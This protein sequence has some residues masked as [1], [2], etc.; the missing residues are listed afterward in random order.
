[1]KEMSSGIALLDTIL[2]GGI[3][4]YST[5]IVAGPPGSGKTILVQQLM[6][7]YIR[8]HENAKVLYL[9]TLSEPSLKVVRYMQRFQFFDAE[10]FGKRA[11]YSDIGTFIFEESLLKLPKKIMELVDL[12]QPDLVTID[13][14]QAIGDLSKNRGEF[15]RLCYNLSVLFA[16][17]RC[18]TFLVS[19]SR[20]EQ[21]VNGA[22][23]AIADGIIYLDISLKEQLA[24]RSLQV[25][26]LRG[27]SP[28]MEVFPFKLSDRGIEILSPNLSLKQK[29][30]APRDNNK[31]IATAIPGL[32]KLLR[33]G[34]PMGRSI[35]LSGVSGTGK[36]TFALQFLVKGA[37]LGQKGLLISFEESSDRLHETASSF[38]W[39]FAE[40]EAKGLLDIVFFPP[41]QIRVE[42]QLEDIVELVSQ[43]QP[44]RL[45]IDSFSVFLYKIKDPAIQ[46]EKI[47][48]LTNLIQLCGAVGLLL[49]DIPASAPESLSRFGVEETVVDGTIILTTSKSDPQLSTRG[50]RRMRYLE[51]Y[52]M[53]GINHITGSHPFEIAAD[54]IKILNNDFAAPINNKNQ[55]SA[56]ISQT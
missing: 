44:D 27:K 18:T 47:I 28:L 16:T 35:L 22:E 42:E 20:R 21:I 53:R 26:K 40:I 4:I 7:N 19:E 17:A 14:F 6:F 3:P 29:K 45:V 32:D 50:M 24:K 43:F 54:G 23:F 25:C 11:I 31:I 48:Q 1:M 46:R 41:T 34:I 8:R 12:H 30:F 37:E 13:S 9:S 55:I 49:S 10:A 33:G 51:V 39:N 15:R 2:G 38:G 52:K 5:N 36:T 56:D